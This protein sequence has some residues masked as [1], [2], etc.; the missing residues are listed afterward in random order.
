MHLPIFMP[1]LNLSQSA[2]DA[3]VR[4]QFG[5]EEHRRPM[6][7]D[8]DTIALETARIIDD[9]FARSCPGGRV[10]R[11]AKV[12]VAVL[13]ALDEAGIQPKATE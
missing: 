1:F 3:D 11:T 10:Q 12:Q 4:E 8:R 13:A 5:W 9:I 2:H 6:A 7:R